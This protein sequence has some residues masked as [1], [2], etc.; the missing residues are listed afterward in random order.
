M[1]ESGFGVKEVRDNNAQLEIFLGIP[2]KAAEERE[3]WIKE[4]KAKIRELITSAFVGDPQ[5]RD[6][7][8]EWLFEALFSYRNFQQLKLI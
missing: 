2:P 5:D 8:R 6:A 3:T 1:K 4:N 7:K